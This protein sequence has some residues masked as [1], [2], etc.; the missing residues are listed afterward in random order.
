MKSHPPVVDTGTP[1]AGTARAPHDATRGREANVVRRAQLGVAAAVILAAIALAAVA[2]SRDA[3]RL[4]ATDNVPVNGVAAEIGPGDSLCRAEV[5]APGGSAGVRAYV[6]PRPGTGTVSRLRGE[7]RTPGAP[8]LQG[9]GTRTGAGPLVVEFP[10]AAARGASGT[11]CFENVG[12]ATIVGFGGISRGS[13]KDSPLQV[14]GKRVP[15]DLSVDVVLPRESLVSAVDRIA[16]RATVWAPSWVGDWTAYVVLL[17]SIGMVA[18]AVALMVRRRPHPREAWAIAAIALVGGVGWATILPPWQ[19]PDEIEHFA[20]VQYLGETGELPGLPGALDRPTALPYSKEHQYA[21]E[22]SFTNSVRHNAQAKPPWED[23]AFDRWDALQ[24]RTGASPSDG[25]G[26]STASH[27]PPPYYGLAAVGYRAFD[28]GTIFD[29]LFGARLLAA[30]LG[31]LSVLC[32]WLFARELFGRAGLLPNTAALSVALLP[33]FQFMS[34]ITNND[35]LLILMG[36]LELYLI[37]RVIRRGVTPRIAVAMGVVL[38]LG[39][40]T[41][42]TMVAF[43]PAVAAVL[44]WPLLH[45][46]RLGALRPALIGFAGFIGVWVAWGLIAA[47]AGRELW[48][49]EASG[50]RPFVLSDFLN[51]FWHFYLPSLPGDVDRYFGDRAPV[52][53]V[54]MHSFFAA[55]GWNDTVF[56]E[57]VYEVITGVCIA[58][59]VLLAA[60]AWRERAALRRALPIVAAGA[61]TT[62]VLLVFAHLAFYLYFSGF[63]GEQGRYLLPLAPLFGAA[64]AASSLAVGRRWAPVLCTLYV[65]AL[66]CLATFSYGLALMRYYT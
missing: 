43:A 29:R 9:V 12:D 34:G 66:A 7:L 4:A 13:A 26:V 30:L 36:S 42:P 48:P 31:A 19:A 39:Y 59:G 10:A 11:V 62:V 49:T 33:Q 50:A 6:V 21:M 28:G 24:K 45:E 37:A 25:G 57:R 61:V 5:P 56:P 55:F 65:T 51:Y 64:V 58:I 18:L 40:L 52:Y 63:P 35:S 23:S 27:Y 54:W 32:V 2:L 15:A 1:P 60:A 16:H 41:K 47:L 46:R 8:R 53:T 38:A 20:Y 3:R 17:L 14:E 44:A 22:Q